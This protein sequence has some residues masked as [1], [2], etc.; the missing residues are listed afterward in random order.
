MIQIFHLTNETTS[1]RGGCSSS[2]G[3]EPLKF[4]INRQKIKT[5]HCR[6]FLGS[7]LCAFGPHSSEK[8]LKSLSWLVTACLLP[9]CPCCL[10]T[11]YLKV[12]YRFKK[13]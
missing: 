4:I 8:D 13:C 1:D 11:V 12:E 10:N 2:V 6:V 9:K 3:R 7:R 5:L